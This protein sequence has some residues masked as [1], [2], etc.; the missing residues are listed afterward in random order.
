LVKLS[1]YDEN[2]L[3]VWKMAEEGFAA[4]FDEAFQAVEMEHP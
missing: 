1:V 3:F 2:G 4:A